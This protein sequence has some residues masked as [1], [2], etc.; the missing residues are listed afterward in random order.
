MFVWCTPAFPGTGINTLAFGKMQIFSVA[1]GRPV[2]DGLGNQWRIGRRRIAKRSFCVVSLSSIERI[3][4]FNASSVL[5]QITILLE[6]SL[7][8]SCFLCPIANYVFFE[9]PIQS[10]NE[11]HHSISS[12]TLI[13]AKQSRITIILESRI[14]IILEW[15]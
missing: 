5:Q 11:E 1:T 6:S 12:Q 9:C 14:T 8:N 7:A 4:Y 13:Y 2:G 10:F 3:L 15:R